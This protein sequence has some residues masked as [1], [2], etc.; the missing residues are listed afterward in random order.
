MA[1]VKSDKHGGYFPGYVRQRIRD[2]K[3][4]IAAVTGPTGSGKS[5]SVLRQGENL[6]DDFNVDNVCFTATQFMNLINGKTKKLHKGSNILFDEIQITL[7]HLDYQSIQAKLLNYILQ[8]F[9]HRNF[10]LWVTTPNF[11]FIN[12]AARKLFH[13][14]MET[15]SIN[16]EK[17]H[18]KL[19][20]L[21]IQINQ[22]K[23]ESYEKY[24]RVWHKDFGIVPLKKLK[25]GMPSKELVDAYE[26]K[27][28]EFTNNLN[29]NIA[30][31]LERIDKGKVKQKP[32]TPQ[33]AEIIEHI[34]EGLTLDKVAE[35]MNRSK[36]LVYKQL[37]LIGN[38]G[39]TIKPIKDGKQVLRYEVV[40]YD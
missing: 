12:A 1:L 2:N 23:G 37:E 18:V 13:C 26:A 3:N 32:L 7:G 4:F 8:T 25:I 33:Q 30:R 38:K 22:R 27:K 34:K 10:V 16:K 29:E 17:Q 31:D 15:I 35:R 39:I 6:D 24:L 28:T 20:P 36:E 19:K 40:G 5:Y 11:N 14:R 21:L 9:R